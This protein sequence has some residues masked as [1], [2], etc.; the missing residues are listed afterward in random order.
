MN[1]SGFARERRERV[2]APGEAG[3]FTVLF[4]AGVVGW[5]LDFASAL[6]TAAESADASLPADTSSTSVA[7]SSSASSAW[8]G[9]A[10]PVFECAPG[11]RTRG[12]MDERVKGRM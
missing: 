5:F 8:P 6:C 3:V 7:S 10:V 12:L 4:T 1:K 11:K 9:S 2:T